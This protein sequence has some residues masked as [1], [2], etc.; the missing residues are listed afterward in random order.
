MIYGKISKSSD[1]Y[2]RSQFNDQMN[3]GGELNLRDFSEG[4]TAGILDI[5]VGFKTRIQNFK[6]WISISNP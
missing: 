3:K 1:W 5:K 4:K 6:S 2:K